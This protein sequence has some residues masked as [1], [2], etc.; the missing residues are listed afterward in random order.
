MSFSAARSAPHLSVVA[1]SRNDNHGGD[2]LKRMQL[3]VSCLAEQAERHELPV[4][5]IM[6]EWNP[7]P[8][9]PPLRQALR[10]PARSDFFVARIVT[11]PTEIH[12]SF[13]PQDT[14]PLFQMIA[15]NVGIRRAR[16]KFILATN[17]DLIFPDALMKRLRDGLEGGILYRADRHDVLRTIPDADIGLESLLEFCRSNV[18][19]KHDATGT[20]TWQNGEWTKTGGNDFRSYWIDSL[21]WIFRDRLLQFAIELSAR[22]PK[23]AA[24]E[25]LKARIHERRLPSYQLSIIAALLGWA[26]IGWY[27]QRN[28]RARWHQYGM[29]RKFL[30]LHTNGC[31]DFTLLDR[32][33]WFRLRG[34]V[35]WPIFSW[36][37]DSLFLLQAD[38]NAIPFRKLPEAQCCYHV[39][40]GGGW[41]PE[42]QAALF[43]RLATKGI[44]VI[45][46]E[47]FVRLYDEMESRGRAGREVVYNEPNWGLADIELAEESIGSE[48]S[49]H[50]DGAQI[51]ATA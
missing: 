31:G 33:T 49:P 7:P 28:W 1:T 2:L 24:L 40:H 23:S 16:G 50:R 20:F 19:R 48:Q 44:R 5:L 51:A 17:I 22:W 26:L 43:E 10:W 6:V 36:H 41:T 11:V 9:R 13:D 14:L 18:I 42:E 21:G 29:Q 4:E 35:E 8:E 37:L 12:R 32:D 30:R 47:E 25:R 34:Y 45:S 39:D 3:F 27:Y 46:F 38:A 15:K